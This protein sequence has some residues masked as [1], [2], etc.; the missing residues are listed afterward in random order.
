[1][2]H[3]DYFYPNQAS[4]LLLFI[5]NCS[6]YNHITNILQT[7]WNLLTLTYNDSFI[8][9]L[10]T[11]ENQPPPPPP[12]CIYEIVET[13]CP[14]QKAMIEDVEK[15]MRCA[16]GG[17]TQPPRQSNSL[18][19]FFCFSSYRQKGISKIMKNE[20]EKE[21]KHCHILYSNYFFFLI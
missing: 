17:T 5:L 2:Q 10:E 8:F 1:M 16:S 20:K 9:P 7:I 11:F 14:F 19:F 18:S 4:K 12:V 6:G 3:K 13:R 21:Q 15:F